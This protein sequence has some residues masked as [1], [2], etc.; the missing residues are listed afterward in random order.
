MRKKLSLFLLCF[1]CAYLLAAGKGILAEASPDGVAIN[2]KNFSSFVISKAKAMDVNKDGYLSKQ[3]AS[4]LKDFSCTTW[5]PLNSFKG[6]EHFYNLESIDIE[7]EYYDDEEEGESVVSNSKI[8]KAKEAEINL[9]G[10]KKLKSC[11]IIS[12]YPLGAINLKGCTSLKEATIYIKCKELNLTGCKKLEHL[13]CRVSLLKK[14][15][16][17]ALK[18]LNKAI[19]YGYGVQDG[20]LKSLDM[21]NCKNM[22]ELYIV[23]QPSLSSLNLKGCGKL[24]TLEIEG[25]TL[26]K[27]L[28]LSDNVRLKY[29]TC[30][31]SKIPSFDFRKNVKLKKVYLRDQNQLEEIDL[32]K[33]I[34]L[35]RLNIK[36]CGKLADLDVRK[37]SKL[38]VLKCSNTAV[39]ELN[40]KKNTSLETLDCS[41]TAISSLNLKKNPK[42]S[43]LK[44]TSTNIWNL[45]LSA[46]QIT[47]E[48]GVKCDEGVSVIFPTGM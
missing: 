19:I 44:C 2:E 33:C 37:N 32:S 31:G 41:N 4:K 39:T 5:V 10:L 29:F 20:N 47:S 11:Y 8:S 6:I 36:R 12:P 35:T 24:E 3:E 9:S 42:L 27:K 14:L 17:S 38:K 43:Y 13:T 26:L 7:P 18:K 23:R 34:K 40:L 30:L 28:D 21:S 15:D 25:S 1:A 16:L 48:S 45:D 22:K 46:T